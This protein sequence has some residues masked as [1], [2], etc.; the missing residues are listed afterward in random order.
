ML[1]RRF[2][3][4]TGFLAFLEGIL[5]FSV[6]FFFVVPSPHFS[7]EY[8]RPSFQAE[9]SVANAAIA[10]C[11][12]LAWIGLF[13]PST[14]TRSALIEMPG[15]FIQTVKEYVLTVVLLCAY[16]LVV[17]HTINLA[18]IFALLLICLVFRISRL[19]LGH[20]LESRDPQL[21]IIL[22]SGRRAGK[23]WREIRTR[24]HSTVKLAGFVDD[25]PLSEMPPDIADRYLGGINQLDALLFANAVDKLIVA[26]PMKS[27]YEK[28]QRAIGIA[29][30]AGVQ[31]LCMRDS[32]PLSGRTTAL[33]G[34]SLFSEL[35]PVRERHLTN[36]AIKR[37]VD[38]LVALTCFSLFLPI[39]CLVS[40]IIK[41]NS[42]RPVFLAEDR[43]GHRRRIFRVYLFNVFGQ[44]TPIIAALARFLHKTSLDKLPLLLNVLI[45]NMS[46]VG[47]RPMRLRDVSV[48]SKA[49]LMR[50]FTVKPGLTGLWS[51]NERNSLGF[52]KSIETDCQYID[53]WSLA[54]DFH[55]LLKTI[56]VVF[57]RTVPA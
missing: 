19:A 53:G 20:W 32:Y 7:T 51:V 50:R 38:F 42:S 41:L 39:F 15:K 14:L 9:T 49:A 43:L 34:D 25:R 45:G 23:T 3:S 13:R 21:V 35:V 57:T 12:I 31:I 48:V 2:S 46:L 4:S 54:L 1:A 22:G 52:E 55:I 17:R 5:D 27:C 44:K 47:P 56:S 26:L 29:E 10:C 30:Q 28:A 37:C 16:L 11:F 36:Q 24:F 6:V 33:L 18:T 40:A 8:L